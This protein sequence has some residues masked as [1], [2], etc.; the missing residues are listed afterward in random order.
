LARGAPI[1]ISFGPN[2]FEWKER[3][4]PKLEL[5]WSPRNVVI[6]SVSMLNAADTGSSNVRMTNNAAEERHGALGE[7]HAAVE[8]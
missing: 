2:S 1:S 6:S 5:A 4:Y 7:Q 8:K 3:E